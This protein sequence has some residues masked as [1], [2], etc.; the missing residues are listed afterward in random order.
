[1]AHHFFPL[2][3]YNYSR[4]FILSGL[5]LWHKRYDVLR[6]SNLVGK[7]LLTALVVIVLV[8]ATVKE[9]LPGVVLAVFWSQFWFL[10]VVALIKVLAQD[11]NWGAL[12]ARIILADR[13]R[14]GISLH[15]DVLQFGMLLFKNLK[16]VVLT[17]R[18][19]R[20]LVNMVMYLMNSFLGLYTGGQLAL[21]IWLR[22]VTANDSLSYKLLSDKI[23]NTGAGR[24]V[25]TLLPAN[26][27]GNQVLASRHCFLN[28]P[29]LAEGGRFVSQ[30]SSRLVDILS[31]KM[32]NRLHRSERLFWTGLVSI[33]CGRK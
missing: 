15:Q 10:M 21:S 24:I 17:G 30:S 22:R 6:G 33:H 29:R 27:R 14:A 4:L 18:I 23:I 26:P 12:L 7:I 3:L 11:W 20:L 28:A 13:A 8:M 2:I 9:H 1:M 25:K 32:F 16:R 5:I 31:C 19:N